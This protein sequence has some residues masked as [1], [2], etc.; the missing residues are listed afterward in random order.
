MIRVETGR[1]PA[2]RYFSRT[3]RVSVAWLH[4]TFSSEEIKLVYE[5][6]SK[7]CADICT[8]AFPDGPKWTAACDLINVVDP[9]RIRQFMTDYSNPPQPVAL[10]SPFAQDQEVVGMDGDAL[11][12][13]KGKVEIVLVSSEYDH[14]FAT[15][16]LPLQRGGDLEAITHSVRSILKSLERT[17][18]SRCALCHPCYRT[19]NLR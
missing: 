12:L 5:L 3:H 1:N 2:M 18:H 17:C 10:S 19:S 7:M 16:S 6:S 11:S 13:N 9:Q 15:F 8:K 14:E 4:E